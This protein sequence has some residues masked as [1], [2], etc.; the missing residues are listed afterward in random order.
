MGKMGYSQPLLSSSTGTT[1]QSLLK[2]VARPDV[3]YGAQ[4][5]CT[6]VDLWQL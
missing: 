5:G 2:G 3:R 6:Y 4:E 1:L